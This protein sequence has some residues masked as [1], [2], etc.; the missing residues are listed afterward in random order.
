MSEAADV[1]PPPAQTPLPVAAASALLPWAAL[2]L[3]NWIGVTLLLPL[4]GGGVPMRLMHY[5]VGAGHMLA[6]GALSATAVVA[7]RVTPRALARL[8]WWLAVGA[9]AMLVGIV[10]MWPDL[11]GVTR[12]I[13]SALSLSDSLTRLFTRAGFSLLIPASFIVSFW[14]RRGPAALAPIGAS[15]A[16]FVLN[17]YFSPY[18]NAGVHLIVMWASAALLTGPAR[19]LLDRPESF[20]AGSRRRR[21]VTASI[22]LGWSL[23]SIITGMASGQARVDLSRWSANV[24]APFAGVGGASV[25]VNLARIADAGPFFQPRDNLEP[26]PP[27]ER[28]YPEGEHPIVL[29]V[30][31]DA[32]RADIFDKPEHATYTKNIRALMDR[33]AVFDMARSPGSQTVYTLSTLSTGQYFSQQYWSKRGRE[34]WPHEDPQHH[35]AGLLMDAGVRA[36]IVQGTKFLGPS[37]GVMKGFD[38]ARYTRGKTSK[39]AMANVLTDH[40]LKHVDDHQAKEPLFVFLHYFD[41]HHPYD[42][43]GKEGTEFERYL[44]EV[45]LIDV[46]IQ[47]I[48]DELGKRGL[49]ERTTLIFSSDHG[50]AFGEHNSRWHAT[51]IYEEQLRIPLLVY[52][53]GVKP[54]RIAEP[55]SLVDIGPTVLDLMGVPTPG[56]FMGQSLVPLMGGEDV[57]LVRPIVAETQLKQ[58]MLFR[59]GTKVIR[60]QKRNTIEV[61]DLKSDPGE[62]KNLVGSI[63]PD[64]DAHVQLLLG[65][66]EV[67]TYNRDGYVPP[68]RP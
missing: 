25:V 12:N 32:L 20:S 22:V 47:R 67:Q 41:T 59:D 36:K 26:I 35:L 63:D 52:G 11:P 54:R 24:L 14:L 68:W 51:T 57:E 18:A 38:N 2:A 6:L 15:L 9:A 31:A 21:V 23:A 49:W 46:E 8:P 43:G 60:D 7:W 13:S 30:T 42:R 40:L 4:G 58:A 37:Y 62:E 44:K 1:P 34:Y 56:Q 55:V 19:T 10:V 28:V 64:D 33:S 61:Y 16:L 53:A 29:V 45:Q 39:W 50:E 3:A 5:F 17:N 48:V 66:F 65:F 27:G